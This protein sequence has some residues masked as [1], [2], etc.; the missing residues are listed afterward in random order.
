MPPS[1]LDPSPRDF[2]HHN[3]SNPLLCW[4]SK[5]EAHCMAGL[6]PTRQNCLVGDSFIERLDRCPDLRPLSEKTFPNWLNLGIGGDRVQ[7][8][9]WRMDHGGFPANPGKVIISC[10]TNNI[11]TGSAKES[12]LIANTILQTAA[13]LRT[14][15][16]SI[17]LAILGICPR[18]NATKCRAAELINNK[19]KFRLPASETFVPP[20]NSLFDINGLPNIQFYKSDMIHLNERGYNILLRTIG[21]HMS[22]ADVISPAKTSP[23]KPLPDDYGIGELEFLGDG[24][25]GEATSQPAR[26]NS[27]VDCLSGMPPTLPSQPHPVPPCPKPPDPYPP[28]PSPSPFRPAGTS[29]PSVPVFSVMRQRNRATPP[30]IT[31]APPPAR[32]AYPAS[33]ANTKLACHPFFP[34][35]FTCPR[36]KPEQPRGSWVAHSLAEQF[37]RKAPRR[38]TAP[39]PYKHTPP[40]PLDLNAPLSVQDNEPLHSV[41][42]MPV[43]HTPHPKP[44]KKP[45][46]THVSETRPLRASPQVTPVA[47]KLPGSPLS[48][49]SLPLQRSGSIT[50][51]RNGFLQ[52]PLLAPDLCVKRRNLAHFSLKLGLCMLLATALLTIL[53]DFA[54]TSCYF[55]S[56]VAYNGSEA[57]TSNN[58]EFN[59]ISVKRNF[60]P[61]ILPTIY[62]AYNQTILQTNQC[63]YLVPLNL[64]CLCLFV[65][66]LTMLCLESK[67]NILAKENINLIT[68]IL[69][70]TMKNLILILKITLS[71]FLNQYMLSFMGIF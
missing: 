53:I 69:L 58:F 60:G 12:E 4:G 7:H 10:G 43:R 17:E 14:L 23:R 33:A 49:R 25:D 44:R 67:F 71:I 52:K 8:V 61:I 22:L 56:A 11:C 63:Q 3:L 18:Q 6:S 2:Y 30:P 5:F 45:K 70:I 9:Q 39:A 31:R 1:L 57:N 37:R 36:T 68:L 24:W 13:N 55:Y 32:R 46:G 66:S 27:L 41:K 54:D 35:R 64:N 34:S 42:E 59:S 20:P 51:P 47:Q 16:P 50:S 19:L 26:V 38:P 65:I 48:A 62:N 15:Y 29:S 21:S 28:L 40:P